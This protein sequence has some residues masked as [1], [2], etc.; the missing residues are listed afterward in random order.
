MRLSLR[1]LL[2]VKLIPMRVPTRTLRYALIGKLGNEEEVHWGMDINH[3]YLMSKSIPR[4]LRTL[5]G[6][7][8][9][10]MIKWKLKLSFFHAYTLILQLDRFGCMLIIRWMEL[11]KIGQ[12][13]RLGSIWT[14][15][16][17][18]VDKWEMAFGLACGFALG[19]AAA[20]WIYWVQNGCW[21]GR[22]GTYQAVWIG[23]VGT[24]L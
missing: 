12:F 19:L 9:R 24:Y 21:L 22:C 10:G 18:N 14:T 8:W 6:N 17:N 2:W 7:S 15:W 3:I 11:L 4:L 20:S 16:S 23:W 5:W 1:L 13:N